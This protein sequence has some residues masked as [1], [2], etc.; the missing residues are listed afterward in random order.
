M[1]FQS[2]V[3]SDSHSALGGV[4]M[5]KCSRLLA[6][7]AIS[8]AVL[9]APAAGFAQTAATGNIEGVVTDATGAVLPGVTVV[10]RNVETNLSRETV[11]DEA[12]R[13]RAVALQPGT[14]EVAATLA[15]F[16]AKPVGNVAV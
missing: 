8:L 6:A 13:Y 5:D 9:L 1:A 10:V 4:S 7:A 11:T 16:T 2:P 14:Y 12:G 15:G 3:F